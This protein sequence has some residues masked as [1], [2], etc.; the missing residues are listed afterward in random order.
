MKLEEK[1]ELL[2]I[3]LLETKKL[4]RAGG[5]IAEPLLEVSEPLIPKT[6]ESSVLDFSYNLAAS[7]EPDAL[8]EKMPWDGYVMSAIIDWPDGCSNL[9]GARIT[10]N[11][12]RMVPRNDQWVALN[13][14]AIVV[15][16]VRYAQ[17]GHIIRVNLKNNDTT[18]SH[19]LTVLVS[20]YNYFPETGELMKVI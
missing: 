14:V 18:H 20:I 13:N 4:L 7:E 8:E 9:A 12:K 10:I 16:V 5:A 1:V 19:Y 3:E 2:E 17:K 15:P 11:D 6:R